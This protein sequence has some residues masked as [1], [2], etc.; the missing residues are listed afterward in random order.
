MNKS[1][2]DQ[3]FTVGRLVLDP[4]ARGS[5]GSSRVLHRVS[6]DSNRLCFCGDRVATRKSRLVALRKNDI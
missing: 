2:F 5:K 6:I 3:D 4:S 1:P